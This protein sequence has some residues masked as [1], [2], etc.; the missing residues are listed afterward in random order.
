[1]RTAL[2]ASTASASAGVRPSVTSSAR[3]MVANAWWAWRIRPRAAAGDRPTASEVRS[4]S[5]SSSRRTSS[6]TSQRSARTY[7]RVA[8]SPVRERPRS[9]TARGTRASSSAR[10]SPP[11]GDLGDARRPRARTTARRPR[12]AAG[13]APGRWPRAPPT[14]ASATH[15]ST[16]TGSGARW[17]V[18]SSTISAPANALREPRQW[19]RRGPLEREDVRLGV[20][21]DRRRRGPATR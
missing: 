13:G 5:T 10:S 2:A 11:R 9:G 3:A 6:A 14:C 4:C 7:G 16:S 1:M 20:A 18:A 15:A 8:G 19:R 21:G 17:E 12:R